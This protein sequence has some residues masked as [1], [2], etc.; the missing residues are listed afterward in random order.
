M[1]DLAVRLQPRPRRDEIV[2]ERNGVLTRVA[3]VDEGALHRKFS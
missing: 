1:A 3:D 2:G